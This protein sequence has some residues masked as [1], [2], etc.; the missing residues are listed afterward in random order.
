MNNK[1]SE[2]QRRR[3]LRL[4]SVFPVQFQVLGLDGKAVSE[5]MQGFT[6]NVSRGG[7]LLDA[8][9]IPEEFATVVLNRQAKISVKIMMPLFSPA[10]NAIANIVWAE[11]LPGGGIRAGLSYE[12]VLRGHTARIMRHAWVKFLAK[13]AAISFI[14]VLGIGLAVNS[15][16]NMQLIKG[17]KQLVSQL[18]AILRESTAAKQKIKDINREKED[19]QL[20]IQALQ[21][22]IQTM[23]EEKNV[24]EEKTKLAEQAKSSMEERVRAENV[25]AQARIN[26]LKTMIDKL[27]VE[28]AAYQDQLIRL[29]HKESSV[30]EELLRLSQKKTALEK[31]NFDKM[32]KWIVVH[33]N[34]RT[35]LVMSFEGDKDVKDWA[36]IYDQS[37]AVQ[38]YMLFSDF[39]RSRKTLDFFMKKAK[40]VDGLFVNAYYVNDGAPSEFIT[41][42]GPN[43]WIGIAA[44]QYTRKTGDKRYMPLA[45]SLAAAIIELQKQDPDG[46]IRGGPRE[47][48]YASEHNLDAYAFFNMMYRLTG[49]TSYL[50]AMDKVLSWLLLHTY[51]KPEVPIK[52]GKGDSTIATDTYAW[53]I[54]ALGPEKLAELGL[55][56]EKIMDFAET[57]CAVTVPVTSPN[58][59][60]VTIKGFDFAPQQHVSRGGVISTEWTAQMIISL[61]MMAEYYH[62][63][64][65]PSKAVSYEQRADE[66]LSDLCNLIISSPSPTGQ[67]EGCLPY[68][69][70]D[71]VDTGHGWKTPKGKSTGSVS[72]TA[73]TI[74]AYYNMNPLAFKD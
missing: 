60:V 66:Y 72:G 36:F 65:M 62:K 69:S 25:Q 47:Q 29:Q 56:P 13:P 6:H 73:Y 48:W 51:D 12:T 16:I 50:D 70:V 54:A 74:F 59:Q 8:H 7:V 21:L 61:R 10:V 67:G 3:Y 24:L 57:N 45:E 63:K 49:K 5:W 64:N 30:T 44:A 4:D 71:F 43:I 52:R 28:K 27:T 18:I 19:A 58:G 23:D 40:R 26:N 11:T 33:Q 39:E 14:A 32:Y 20:K 41:R 37:L 68:A 31:A 17:N 42:S 2:I 46:G 34:P 1:R 22:R 55:N 38:T 35:G 15:Y 53:S 9:I